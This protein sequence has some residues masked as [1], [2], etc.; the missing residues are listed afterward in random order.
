M[1]QMPD[2]GRFI[3]KPYM[4]EQIVRDIDELLAA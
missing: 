1:R 4:P 2:N 3:P